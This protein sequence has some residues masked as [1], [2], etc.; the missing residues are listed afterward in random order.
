MEVPP[1]KACTCRVGDAP[2]SVTDTAFPSKEDAYEQADLKIFRRG[3]MLSGQTAGSHSH[4]FLF[5]IRR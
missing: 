5:S 4:R 3:S 2:N 1:D